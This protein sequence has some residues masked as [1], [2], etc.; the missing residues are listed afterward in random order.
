MK[1]VIGIVTA[2]YLP[3]LGG[4]ERYVHNFA[5]ELSARNYKVIIITS[6]LPETQLREEQNGI[7]IYRLPSFWFMNDRLPIIKMNHMFRE[8]IQELD[9]LPFSQILINTQLYLMSV[10]AV[11]YCK[12]RGIEPWLIEHAT[13]H[14]FFNNKIFNII[15]EMYEHILTGYIKRRCHRYMGVSKECNKWLEHFGIYTEEVLYN[16]VCEE[17]YSSVKFKFREKLGI[18]R[19]ACVISY[20]GR[21]IPE[22]GIMKLIQ[23]SE[24]VFDQKPHY[25][26]IAG[27]G[28][29]R[30]TIEKLRTRY[31]IPLG[32]LSH[33]DT[34]ALL[35]ET[36]LFCFPS[37]YPEGFP[38][39]LLEAAMCGCCVAATP[40]GGTRE[41]ITGPEYGFLLE[42]NDVK[43]IED[44]LFRIMSEP[45]L[46]KKTG[47]HLQQRVKE[48]FTW[49]KTV[50]T[51]EGGLY[52]KN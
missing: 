46:M 44:I 5:S 42:N 25:L 47:E 29:L 26:L 4:V 7:T 19:D 37:D 31:R 40:K 34:I 12:R 21:L 20:V 1:K 43:D 18:P 11:Q 33:S 16:A 38:T 41:L 3:H 51:F 8:V 24:N 39:V 14:I 2:H 17:E 22:K 48:N 15:G 23:A 28:E 45:S 32:A 50:D 52:E 6:Q 27:D 35:C 13:A 30:E 10:W 36:D 9:Q 49:K